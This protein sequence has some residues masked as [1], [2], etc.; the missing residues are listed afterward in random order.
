MKHKFRNEKPKTF[1]I[2][3]EGDYVLEIIKADHFI[4]QG[5]KTNG[6]DV[7]EITFKSVEHGTEFQDRLIAHPSCDWKIDLFVNCFSL[8]AKVGEEV[9]LDP[10]NLIGRRGWCKVFIDTFKGR[11]GTD[12]QNNKIRVFYTDK[13]KFPRAVIDSVPEP[14]EEPAWD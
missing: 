10:E 4:Q 3:P 14:T 1:E 12:R 8:A 11:D 6:S 2:L 7:L 13:E 5:G 9:D